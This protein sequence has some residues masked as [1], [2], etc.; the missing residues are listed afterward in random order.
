MC[1]IKRWKSVGWLVIQY[2]LVFV[3]LVLA[4]STAYA[5]TRR[6]VFEE[7]SVEGRVQKPVIDIFMRRQNL[8]TD[9]KLELRESFLPKILESLE[10]K[11]F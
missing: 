4:A 9:Y 5:Q 3:G 7:I 6:L 10:K 11:P 1:R 2:I 8:H